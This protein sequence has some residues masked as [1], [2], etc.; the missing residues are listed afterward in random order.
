LRLDLSYEGSEFSGWGIQ[1][2]RRTVQG[3]IELALSRVFHCEPHEL[4]TVVAGRTD[5]GVHAIGQVCHADL[6]NEA[7]AVLTRVGGEGRILRRLRGALGKTSPIWVQSV[8]LAPDGFDARFSALSRRYEYRIADSDSTKDPRQ[9]GYTL[10]V[11]D[12]LDLGAMGTLGHALLGVHDFASFCRARPGATTVRELQEFSWRRDTDNVLVSSVVADAF[13]HSMVRSLVGAAV[14]VGQADLSVD[15]VVALR[16]ATTRTSS[17]K[18][19]AAKGLTLCEVK[20]PP[21]SELFDRAEA[22]RSRRTQPTD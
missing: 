22:T 17:W 20:Y 2:H 18:T 14:A 3:D 10:W 5:A 15:Q 1:P 4:R 19:M 16:D 6:P 11:E 8:R 13:C 7:E 12:R 21:D 9:V